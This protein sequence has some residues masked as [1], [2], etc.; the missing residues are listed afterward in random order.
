MTFDDVKRLLT[1]FRGN[2]GNSPHGEF[3]SGRSQEQFLNDPVPF[4][5]DD[6]GNPIKICIPGNGEG[7]AVIQ[8]L[9]GTPGTIWGPGGSAGRMPRS[10]S[11][12][13]DDADIQ[14]ISDW[15]TAQR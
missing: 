5:T 6:S 13:M 10:G 15:I 12:F 4:V 2:I 3:W 7:S 1:Q 8:A 14:S 11:P 9:R